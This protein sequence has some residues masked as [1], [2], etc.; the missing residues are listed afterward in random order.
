MSIA[1]EIERLKSAKQ[2]I[3]A[4]IEKRGVTVSD[5]STLDVYSQLLE[6]VP[7]AVK[8]T[9]TPEEDTDVF[10]INGLG[11]VPSTLSLSCY[12]LYCNVVE[13]SIV[14]VYALKGNTALIWFTDSN[15]QSTGA[16]VSPNVTSI[17]Y[18]G[19]NNIKITIPSANSRGFFKKGY[20]YD[21]VVSGGFEQ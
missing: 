17:V 3:K 21:Y 18:F 4:S 9:F 20:T 7:Y 5:N 11:Y 12:E 16:T 19:E 6:T 2:D 10:E 8:G 13:K 15:K 1:K 14:F